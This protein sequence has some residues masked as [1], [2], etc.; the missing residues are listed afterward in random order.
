MVRTVKVD[1]D[2]SA[3]LSDLISRHMDF[4]EVMPS[5]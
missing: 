4:A 1:F 3:E 5:T 2:Q